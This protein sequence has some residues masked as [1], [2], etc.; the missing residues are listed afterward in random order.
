MAVTLGG[1]LVP[2]ILREEFLRVT[3]T[4]I[5]K[6]LQDIEEYETGQQ[7]QNALR[8]ARVLDVPRP[9]GEL[10]YALGPYYCDL[11]GKQYQ[12]LPVARPA[13]NIP[14]WFTVDVNLLTTY[15]LYIDMCRDRYSMVTYPRMT[16]M[17]GQPLMLTAKHE[18]DDLGTVRAYLNCAQPSD[19][20]LRFVHEEFFVEPPF[21]YNDCDLAMT[22]TLFITDVVNAYVRSYILTVKT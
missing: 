5:L 2:P 9:I 12:I 19:G 11:N 17:L 8:L 20:F 7:P 6:R 1:V 15:R 13:E 18:A 16:E 4:I 10:L 14:D 3:R 22:Q 21:A